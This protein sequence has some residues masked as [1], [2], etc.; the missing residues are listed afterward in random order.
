[1]KVV[2]DRLYS[3]EVINFII[4]FWH[5]HIPTSIIPFPLISYLPKSVCIELLLEV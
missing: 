1:M 5:S 4:P 3:S 2:K